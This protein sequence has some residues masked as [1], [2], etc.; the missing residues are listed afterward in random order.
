MTRRKKQAKTR[1]NARRHTGVQRSS[2]YVR[3]LTI[4]LAA[5]L[6]LYVL[7][8]YVNN[9]SMQYITQAVQMP[10]ANQTRTLAST[11]TQEITALQSEL[12][13]AENS[14][15]FIRLAIG[16]QLLPMA[17][18]VD[19]IREVKDDLT[20]IRDACRF[21]QTV[22]VYFPKD[23]KMLSTATPTYGTYDDGVAAELAALTPT[24]DKVPALQM[25][26]T[27]RFVICW[28]DGS[29]AGGGDS[30]FILSVTLSEEKLSHWLMEM[31]ENGIAGVA[32]M[33]S[34]SQ[35]LCCAEAEAVTLDWTR[36]YQDCAGQEDTS[37]QRHGS[38]E[39]IVC[40]EEIASLNMTMLVAAPVDVY[41]Q[42]V[43]HL[44]SM[45]LLFTI[46]VAFTT[47]LLISIMWR[48]IG[49]PLNS[50]MSAMN[51]GSEGADYHIPLTGGA[52]FNMICQQFNSMMDKIRLLSQE[53]ME[54]ELRAN[55][56]EL[57][58]LQ[59]QIRPHFL[60]N[61]LYLLYRMAR[62]TDCDDIADYTQH[63]S[64][65]YRYITKLPDHMVALEREMEHV[66]NYLSI[67]RFRCGESVEI[68]VSDIP[69]RLARVRIPP[70]T[71]QPVVENAFEHGVKH[72][73][74]NGRVAIRVQGEPDCFT[75]EVE[76][77][78]QEL[79]DEQLAQLQ[80]RLKQGEGSEAASGLQ[81]VQRRLK[82]RGMGEL[83]V[84]R[85]ESGG[86]LATLCF[87]SEQPRG[88]EAEE[89]C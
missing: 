31:Q 5:L 59:Y 65:F 66:E 57:K 62:S 81:N 38:T 21:V 28:P 11:L 64:E 37:I 70:L 24:P 45:M 19:A 68:T 72:M 77:N 89:Q 22:Q 36:L 58:Q 48:T 49:R 55:Q 20:R 61:N 56:A 53:V 60:Y 27:W 86:L 87:H 17:N 51:R 79:T 43:R 6:A 3:T 32:L 39:Y 12:F 8:M 42:P 1:E 50:I 23:R 88:K 4:V 75:V 9:N 47:L 10:V 76:D 71:L 7:G 34:E 29:A 26:G 83:R 67:Q 15:Q 40:A 80:E 2:L 44:N 13:A 73:V 33:R 52:E 82:L 46:L 41:Q 30:G 69:E 85:G 63:L 78:G 84:S 25:D 35:T 16:F 54:G 74:K 14:S 18:R